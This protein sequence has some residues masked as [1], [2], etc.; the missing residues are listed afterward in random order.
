MGA[1]ESIGGR[2]IPQLLPDVLRNSTSTFR[3]PL[4]LSSLALSTVHQ[5]SAMAQPIEQ[6]IKDIPPVT[7]TWVAAA[8]GTSLLVVSCSPSGCS[9]DQKAD[10][11]R[12]VKSWRL[13]S[14]TFLGLQR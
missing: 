7:R 5:S 12:N 11:D 8:I 13:Y 3:P 9:E 10:R 2:R 6:W 14:C 1:N 4:T